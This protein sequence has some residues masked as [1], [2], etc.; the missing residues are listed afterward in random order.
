MGCQDLAHVFEQCAVL[1]T[2]EEDMCLSWFMFSVHG[3]SVLFS[4]AT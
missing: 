3:L 1:Y 4:L 2:S